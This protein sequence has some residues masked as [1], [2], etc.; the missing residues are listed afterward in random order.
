[1][2]GSLLFHRDHLVCRDDV[3]QTARNSEYC[4][5]GT[6]CGPNFV[7]RQQ[8]FI[9]EQLQLL[10]MSERRNATDGE[11]GHLFDE[12]SICLENLVAD[13]PRNGLFVHSVRPACQYQHRDIVAGAKN[14]RLDDL[15]LFASQRLGGIVGSAGRV[16]QLLNGQVEAALV[17]GV[18]E[19]LSAF[20]DCHKRVLP[21]DEA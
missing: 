20:T 4:V 6:G 19:L 1:M 16:R 13:Q 3:C 11:A 21:M 17:K 12:V 18:L 2:I 5:R 15:G 14:Q 9:D 8:V 7:E 10:L